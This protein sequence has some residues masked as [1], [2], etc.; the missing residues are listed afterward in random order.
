[1]D[2]Y[3]KPHISYYDATHHDLKYATISGVQWYIVTLD[4]F[5]DVGQFTSLELTSDGRPCISYYDATNGALRY[6]CAQTSFHPIY[7]PIIKKMQ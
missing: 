4:Y 1:M 6:L 7:L 3:G 5:G 2:K